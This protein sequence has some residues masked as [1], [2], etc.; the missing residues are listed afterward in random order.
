MGFFGRARFGRFVGRGTLRAP[1]EFSADS[2]ALEVERDSSIGTLLA[3]SV[4]VTRPSAP[5]FKVPFFGKERPRLKVLRIEASEVHLEGVDVEVLR[6]DRI[7]LG[8][9]CHVARVIGEVM[10][11]DPSSHVGPESRSPPPHGISR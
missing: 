8:P 5:P 4:I 6:A 11:V 9:D 3:G 1:G 10:A 7:A 2:V